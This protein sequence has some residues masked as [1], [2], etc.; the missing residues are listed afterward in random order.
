MQIRLLTT[1]RLPPGRYQEAL[2]SI[3]SALFKHNMVLK[4]GALY[5]ADRSSKS[6]PSEQNE[7]LDACLYLTSGSA[8]SPEAELWS[9]VE[10]RCVASQKI[11]EKDN[12]KE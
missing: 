12:R 2:A 7:F 9:A 11:S 1:N 3:V 10:L 8:K 4:Y 5:T 6:N